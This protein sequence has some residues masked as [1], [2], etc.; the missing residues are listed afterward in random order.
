[1][2]A[3]CVALAVLAGLVTL[4]CRAN[5]GRELLERELRH[6]E[7]HI[8]HLEDK[9]RCAEEMIAALEDENHSYRHGGAPLVV[10]AQPHERRVDE[11]SP[12]R[13]RGGEPAAGERSP[14][15]G[16]LKPPE[17]KLE[18][19][20]Q[21]PPFRGPP[22]FSPPDPSKPEG[23]NPGPVLPRVPAQ[24][25]SASG[26]SPRPAAAAPPAPKLEEIEDFEVTA[27]TINPELTGPWNADG[28]GGIEG[29]RVVVEPR[30]AAGHV[31]PV[32]GKV[33]IVLM[34]PA[35]EGAAARVARWDFGLQDTADYFGRV[36]SGGMQ[37]DL[38]WPQRPPSHPLVTLHVRYTSGDG[39]KLDAELPLNLAGGPATK[40]AAVAAEAPAATRTP[41][42]AGGRTWTRSKQSPARPLT[43]RIVTEPIPEATV[44]RATIR[45][46]RV[47]ADPAGEL[48]Q[49]A[50]TPPA[51]PRSARL[52][53]WAPYR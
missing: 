5:Q 26:V 53:E 41:P 14:S 42:S 16:D 27:I 3:A 43:P 4:G 1:M 13:P 47:P 44:P 34:D 9:L 19:A 18:G 51:A 23:E 36:A 46:A 30:T 49:A 29:V 32:P 2:K 20:E 50:E 38:R 10:P 40:G 22:E 52:P 15:S 8:Y 37:F 33:S 12:R 35:V 21:A 31:V 25:A 11:P 6:Q 28:L 17:I 45:N 48:P 39:R 24:S 7:D